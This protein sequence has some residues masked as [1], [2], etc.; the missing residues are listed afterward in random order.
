MAHYDQLY[1]EKQHAQFE[2]N[3]LTDLLFKQI[4][5]IYVLILDFSFSVKRHIEVDAVGR[6]RH[7]IK[8]FFGAEAAKFTAKT[9]AILDM[10]A[11]ILENSSAAFQSR[12]FDKLGDMSDSL[13]Q[14]VQDIQRFDSTAR[15]IANSLS[16]VLREFTDFKAAV[17]PKSRWDWLIQDYE[18]HKKAL[19]PWEDSSNI[20]ARLLAQRHADTATWIFDH[21]VYKTWMEEDF[22]HSFLCLAGQQGS[23]KSVVLA[24]VVERL[25]S[26]LNADDSDVIFVNCAGEDGQQLG[27]TVD[28]VCRSIIHEVYRLATKYEQHPDVLEKCNQV[29]HVSK[30]VKDQQ[31]QQNQPGA[32]RVGTKANTHDGFWIPEFDDAITDLALI[33]ERYCIIVVDGVDQLSVAH[34]QE[35]FQNLWAVSA[36]CSA[37][38]LRILAAARSSSPFISHAAGKSDVLT[39]D[40][41]GGANQVDINTVLSASLQSLLGWTEA[42]REEARQHVLARTGSQFSYITNVAIPFLQQP[43]QRPVSRHLARL[44]NGIVDAYQQ[45]LRAMPANYV[46]LLRTALTWTLY[47]AQAVLVHEVMEAFSGIYLVDDG[48]RDKIPES[49]ELEFGYKATPLELQQIEGARGPFLRIFKDSEGEYVVAPQDL[50]QIQKFCSVQQNDHNED[51]EHNEKF[52]ARCHADL[53]SSTTLQL[54]EREV[55]LRLAIQLVKHLNSSLFQRRFIFEDGVEPG[56]DIHNND[57]ADAHDQ[58]LSQPEEDEVQEEKVA[59]DEEVPEIS[60]SVAELNISGSEQESGASVNLAAVK[61]DSIAAQDTTVATSDNADSGYD[62]DDSREEEDNGDV[63]VIKRDTN[64]LKMGESED[65]VP[66]YRYEIAQWAYH[67][68]KADD[69]WTDDEKAVE[70]LWAELIAELDKFAFDNEAAFTRWQLDYFQERFYFA[71]EVGPLH[72]AA[73]FGITYWASHLI[74]VKGLKVSEFSGNHNALQAAARACDSTRMLALLLA[75]P[76]ANAIEYDQSADETSGLMPALHTW[77]RKSGDPKAVQL[78][79]NHGVDFSAPYEKTGDTALHFLASSRSNDPASFEIILKTNPKDGINIRNKWGTTPLHC[80]LWRP[81]VSVELLRA[82]IKAGAD[83]NAENS[84]S[85]RPLQSACRYG[86]TEIVKTLLESKIA[87][88]NDEDS[89]GNTALHTAALSGSDKCVEALIASKINVN[90]QNKQGRTALHLAAWEGHLETVKV[91]V[92][93]SAKL[94]SADGHQRTPF[95]F[96]CYGKSEPT[97]RYLLDTLKEKCF[98]IE[99]INTPSKR[100]RSPLRLAATRGFDH[101]LTELIEMSSAAGLDVPSVLNVQ[102]TKIKATALMRAAWR[103]HVE[104]VRILLSHGIDPSLTDHENRN[105]LTLARS[106]WQHTGEKVFEQIIL[107]LLDHATDEDLRKETELASAAAVHNSVAV[108]AKMHARGANVNHPDAFGWTPLIFAQRLQHAEAER[109][110]KL[111]ASWK[112][113]LPS[114]WVRHSA[115]PAALT[116]DLTG[117]TLTYTDRNKPCCLTTDRPLPAHLDRFYFEVQLVTASQGDDTNYSDVAIGFCDLPAPAFEYPGWAPRRSASSGRSW[118]LYGD[119]WMG[120]AHNMSMVSAEVC[121][122]GDTIGCGVDLT[123]GTIWFTR[124]GERF[125]KEHEGVTGRLYPTIGFFWEYQVTTNFGSEEFRWKASDDRL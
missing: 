4:K 14:T 51:L 36:T 66:E 74:N 80:V 22:A 19:D 28:R 123:D 58:I 109:F 81:N 100:Q 37:R 76:D 46:D 112:G 125:E 93:A 104:C 42:E 25:K 63:D 84:G 110:L 2:D 83:I 91:L 122:A 77:L 60:Q 82:L 10:K 92:D 5:A 68:R 9:Q 18:K 43:F 16:D 102:D 31:Q 45:A 12:S 118:A 47:S 119:G 99:K 105:A 13:K 116:I 95:W 30:K 115:L 61:S 44:P 26:T 27:L 35:L 55:H 32:A 69:M 124:N 78:F 17:K 1:N 39:L 34:Q 48:N 6:A 23:G 121:K 11:K 98:T 88:I 20:L 29:F 64:D 117:T 70:P 89:L 108:L 40:I 87:D 21:E 97:A 53:A 3:D 49:Y 7:A 41:T 65:E 101:I 62:S 86:E 114:R 52:C 56:R 8:D 59:R 54:P 15:E 94:D 85:T 75:Q 50:A 71:S 79:A 107:A 38:P 103:G 111:Q 73:F 120:H 57:D 113:H 96:A 24:S 72:I 33:L 106:Q 90:H 67:A